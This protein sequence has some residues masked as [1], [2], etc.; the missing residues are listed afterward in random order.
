MTQSGA[1]AASPSVSWQDIICADQPAAATWAHIFQRLQTLALA[2]TSPAALHRETVAPDRLLAETAWDLWQQFPTAAPS[3]IAGIR[4]FW[5][6]PITSAGTAVLLLDALSLRELP[7]TVNAAKKRGIEP[8]NITVRA[9][10]VPTETDQFA[11]ALG[12]SGRARLANNQPPAS[13]IFN[14]P[15]VYT[16]VLAD[17]FIDCVGRIAAQP[18]MFLWH[19]WPDEPLIHLH[20]NRP[21]GDTVVAAEIKRTLASDGFWAFLDRLRQGRRLLITSDHGYATTADFS[22]EVKAP[23]DVRQLAGQ[24]GA[25][26]AVREDRCAP[27]LQRQ[28]PPPVLRFP[29]A[30][31]AWLLVA[32]QRKWKV[33]GGFPTLCHRGLSL[34][35]AAVPMIELPAI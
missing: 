27:W 8:A 15:D 23:E 28:F 29:D 20:S 12:L 1:P 19:N 4:D 10:V 21:D 5:Q 30:R 2:A 34:L 17:P 22:S 26:R 14:G 16:D 31:G 13:F 24:F 7:L 32:G 11:A 35:E 25:Q 6:P 3:V 18:R 9:S 33:S